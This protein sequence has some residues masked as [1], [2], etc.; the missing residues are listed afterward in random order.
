MEDLSNGQVRSGV[1][2]GL[3]FLFLL[4]YPSV[5]IGTINTVSKK[6]VP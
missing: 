3:L 2:W 1:L 5:N 6:I 4:Y